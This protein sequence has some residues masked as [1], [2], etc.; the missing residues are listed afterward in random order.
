MAIGAAARQYVLRG[1][2]EDA[3]RAFADA[4]SAAEEEGKKQEEEARRGMN[5][6]PTNGT[7]ANQ[8]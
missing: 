5:S 3:R 2:I 1:S 4:K 8:P 7:G 6:T